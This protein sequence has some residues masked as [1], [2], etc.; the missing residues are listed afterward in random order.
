MSGE[1]YLKNNVEFIVMSG[2]IH[3]QLIDHNKSIQCLL[4]ITRFNPC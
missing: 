4:K 1:K 2:Y 3:N